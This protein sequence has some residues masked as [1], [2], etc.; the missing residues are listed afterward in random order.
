[1]VETPE[2]ITAQL[3]QYLNVNGVLNP[4]T[5]LTTGDSFFNDGA[6]AA[7]AA[8][9]SQIP[10]LT[11]TYLN[12]AILPATPTWTHANLLA[13][14]FNK[15]PV[16]DIDAIWAHYSQWLAQPAGLP[17]IF[18][19]DDFAT[20]ADL[21]P[22]VNPNAQPVNGRLIFTVGCHSG[23]NVPNTLLLPDTPESQGTDVARRF[24]DWAQS[25][26]AGAAA[27]Y[28][29]NT[30]FGYGDTD[31]SDLSERLYDHFANNINSGGTVGEQWVRALHQY[32]SEPSSY[33]V[34]DEKVMVEASMYGLPFYTFAGTP[35]HTPPA[36]TPPTHGVEGGVD[37]AH[38]PAITDIHVQPSPATN[39]ATLFSDP[40]K[41][42]GT[43]FTQNG[44]PYTMGTLSVFYRPAQPTVSRDVTVPGTSAH[45]VWVRSLTTHT[46]DNM[47]P[48]KPFPLVHSGADKPYHDYPNIFF[49]AAA[50][51]VNRDVTFGAQHDTVV[52]NLGRFFPNTATGSD[53]EKGNEQVVDSVG[54]DVG[55]STS[56][57]YTPPTILQ[58]SAVLN[59]GAGTVT[60]F[61]RVSDAAGVARAAVLYHELGS[62]T[63]SVVPLDHASGDLW[64]K[65][66]NETNPIQ[67]DSE[68][69]DVNGNGTFSANKAVNFS[70]VPDTAAGTPPA[71]TITAPTTTPDT[72][73]VFTLNQNVQA[74]FD[75]SSTVGIASCN[76]ATDGGA[77]IQSGGRLDTSKPGAHSFTVAAEDVAGHA[78]TKTVTYVVKIAFGG[79]L[80][81]VNNPPMLNTTNAGSIV[82]LKWTLLDANGAT[83][84]TMTAIQSISSKLVRCPD[85]MTD[86]VGNTSDIPIGTTGV[87][88]VTAGVFH[89]NW[90][91]SK[92]WA[93]SCRKLTVLLAD[94]STPYANF[95]FK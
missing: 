16:P 59:T 15:N 13:S 39:G 65:T 40:L 91:T 37:T 43:T 79:F 27:V 45:G 31:V 52:A 11:S 56:T 85:A 20:T 3:G 25:Y 84:A 30:G 72:G 38:L 75:C 88:G 54:L 87:A 34:I 62:G 68:A 51:T 12:P 2:D 36:V 5:A 41:P 18:T 53:P 28:V 73:G 64:T 90:A 29:A 66:F 93:G 35:Q 71:I 49:P 80:D 50:A 47:R 14:F 63:W 69:M 10:G 9:R 55:Y 22:A 4:H 23:L 67:L 60:A 44:V 92:S 82:P 81:P 58:T 33:D 95:Q 83:Y 46:I 48:Y 61:V 24:R 76:G 32:Y 89:F 19:V 57:D 7:D 42:D 26:G 70:S 21:N 8:L 94:G 86:P 74:Q 17:P 1:M 6:A 77:P 78:A